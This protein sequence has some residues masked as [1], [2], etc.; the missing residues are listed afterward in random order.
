MSLTKIYSVSKKEE[1]KDKLNNF[2][3]LTHNERVYVVGFLKYAGYSDSEIVD[4]F[5]SF[6]INGPLTAFQVNSIIP[7]SFIKEESSL[8]N[9]DSGRSP[10]YSSC[11]RSGMTL[12][13]NDKV[14][15]VHNNIPELI[16]ES[17][18]CDVE[19]R[20]N[21]IPDGD[22]NKAFFKG[23]E[24]I[25]FGYVKEGIERYNIYGDF[26]HYNPKTIPVYRSIKGVDHVLFVADVDKKDHNNSLEEARVYALK[27]SK[28]W[29]WDIIKFSGSEGFHLIKYLPVETTEE[30]LQN[31]ALEFDPTGGLNSKTSKLDWH[32]FNLTWKIRGYCVN[33]KTGLLSDDI[34]L[35]GVSYE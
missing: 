6:G 14:I 35:E 10:E 15:S 2:G 5:S 32:L 28:L 21:I 11:N 18:V 23:A 12:S 1:I 9:I 30:Q 3:G 22:K 25:A 26:F 24:I 13:T 19:S 29:D 17:K 34:N 31:K 16:P 27:I 8:F 7:K 33:L 4:V 20:F